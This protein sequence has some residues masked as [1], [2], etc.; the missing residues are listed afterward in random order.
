VAQCGL[1]AVATNLAQRFD[2]R[3]VGLHVRRPFETPVFLEGGFGMGD[4]FKAC[5]EGAKF[6][7]AEAFDTFAQA[8]KG[9]AL[10][11]E[12]RTVDGYVDRDLSV[13]PR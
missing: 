6:D 12:W 7:E 3:L 10:V 2:A 13:Q 1:S 5:N 9:K 4:F 11:A 8:T